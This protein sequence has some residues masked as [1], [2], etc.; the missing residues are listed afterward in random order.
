MAKSKSEIKI[1]GT[2]TY[3]DVEIGGCTARITG[4]LGKKC[5]ICNESSINKWLG[6]SEIITE[7]EKQ[8]LI[9]KIIQKTKGLHFEIVFDENQK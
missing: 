9:Q 6:T 3:I 1:T 4:E 2:N 8:D 7:E 5:F